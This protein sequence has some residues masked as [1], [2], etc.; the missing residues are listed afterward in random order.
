[1]LGRLYNEE[2]RHTSLIATLRKARDLGPAFTQR[3]ASARTFD[4]IFTRNTPRDPQTSATFQAQPEPAW[5]IDYVA[6]GK[7]LGY[8]GKDVAPGIIEHARQWESSSR[9]SLTTPPPNSP[10]SSLSKSSGTSPSTTSPGWRPLGQAMA[11]EPMT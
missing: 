11:T 5:T 7:A 10:R 2:Y 8:L 4:H 6:L 3:N 9:R 1:V